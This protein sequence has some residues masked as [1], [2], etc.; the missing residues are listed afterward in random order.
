M[1][2][3]FTFNSEAGRCEKFVYGGCGAGAN[4]FLTLDECVNVCIEAVGETE[5]RSEPSV[6]IVFPEDDTEQDVCSLPPITLS[7]DKIHIGISDL[8]SI[9]FD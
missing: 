9:Q 8:Y 2:P 6:D 3:R 5:V 1:F 4:M 7:V